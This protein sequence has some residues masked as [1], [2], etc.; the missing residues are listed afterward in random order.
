MVPTTGAIWKTPRRTGIFS[1]LSQLGGPNF[2]TQD[3]GVAYPLTVH[4]AMRDT[5][6][7]KAGIVIFFGDADISWKVAMQN[8]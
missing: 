1:I 8:S 2:V 3:E 4:S 5:G 6:F 7:A